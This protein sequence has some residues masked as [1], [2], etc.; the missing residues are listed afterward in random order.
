MKIFQRP[1]S[2][3]PFILCGSIAG[4]YLYALTSHQVYDWKHSIVIGFCSALVYLCIPAYKR[5]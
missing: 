2:H 5:Q 1:L 3:T 4:G